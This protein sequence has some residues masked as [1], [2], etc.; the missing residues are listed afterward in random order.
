MPDDD[1]SLDEHSF[2]K[3]DFK[4]HHLLRNMAGG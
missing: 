2:E 4:K 1:F 3:V